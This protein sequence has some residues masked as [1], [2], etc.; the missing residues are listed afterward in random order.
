MLRRLGA[1]GFKL[2]V[3]DLQIHMGAGFI[4]AVCGKIMLMP[5]LPKVPN[6]LNM[7]ITSDGVISGL[8]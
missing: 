6:A 2:S 8:A 7:K 4:V 3:K 1:R 5:G